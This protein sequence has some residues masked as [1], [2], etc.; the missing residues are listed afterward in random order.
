MVARI[1]WSNIAASDHHG[2]RR[3]VTCDMHNLAAAQVIGAAVTGVREQH[4]GAV[5]HG[6]NHGRAGLL[7]FAQIRR[8]RLNG[9]VRFQTDTLDQLS[10]G[11]LGLI[12]KYASRYIH[13]ALGGQ[14]AIGVPAHAVGNDQK[15]PRA[16]G[17]CFGTILVV[18]PV[19]LQADE[20]AR[21]P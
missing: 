16:G 5:N 8:H 4:I 15:L 14:G 10:G 18:V 3:V 12:G 6:T 11:L 13:D 2:D 1:L 20:F 19:T 21:R 9:K 7:P 17:E